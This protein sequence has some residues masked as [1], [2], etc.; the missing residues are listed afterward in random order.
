M[1]KIEVRHDAFK[2]FKL[3]DS[4]IRIKF[5][6]ISAK[7]GQYDVPTELFQKRTNRKNRCL[8]SW[9]TVKKNNLTMPQLETF[10]GGVAVEFVNEDFF[11]VKNQNDPLFIQ[12]KNKLGSDDIVSS[13]ITIRSESGNSSSSIQRENF[14]KL[15]NNVTIKYKNDYVTINKSNYKDYAIKQ[16]KPGGMGNEK[17]EGFLYVSIKGGQQDT[18]ESHEKLDFTIFNPACEY[19]TEDVCEDINLVMAYFAFM[20]INVS[21]LDHDKKRSYDNTL[22]N[23]RIILSQ[24]EY[25]SG[26]LLNYCD[27]HPCLR[28]YPGKLYD[29]IQIEEINIKDFA[30]KDKED[31]RNLDF[32]HNEAVNIGRFYWDCHK[33][34]ILSPARPTNVFWS[35][36]L[37]NMMQQ[38]FTLDEYFRHQEEIVKRRNYLLKQNVTV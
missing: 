34:C 2:F 35:K 16:I 24:T 37:S 26:N 12:L 5:D 18:I 30:I 33:Q 23:M 7:T 13:I 10:Y 25:D 21:T 28:M 3:L 38:N 32:T 6:N 31:R 4:N 27:N 14:K 20:S 19:A 29:P 15:I 8:I 22:K 11:N 1:N 9:K 36:H 17:W